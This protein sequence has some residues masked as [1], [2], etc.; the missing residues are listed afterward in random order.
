MLAQATGE[1]LVSMAEA[2]SHDD[3]HY[4][5]QPDERMGFLFP[6]HGWRPPRL[7]REF[8]GKLTIDGAEGHFCYVLATAGDD[9]GETMDIFGRDLMAAIGISPQSRYSLLMPNTYVGLPFMDVD[10]PEKEK[11]KCETARQLLAEFIAYIRERRTGIIRTVR[12][13]WPSI[14]SNLLGGAFVRWIVSDKPFH[15]TSD[16]IECGKCA[17]VCPVG[18]ILG[19]KGQR[20][21]WKHNGQCLSCFACYHHCPTR[22]IRYGNRTEKKGQYYY[23]K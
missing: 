15:A 10:P 8:V 2:L 4:A 12:G 20:P 14:N 17:Q 22:A 21:Q 7:V 9:I 19:G 18:N 5:L 16:C 13:K 11:A 3:C 6:V 23:R 1:R